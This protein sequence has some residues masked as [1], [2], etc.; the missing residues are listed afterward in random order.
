MRH[1]ALN[2]FWFLDNVRAVCAVTHGVTD[3][4]KLSN[5]TADFAGSDTQTS[6]IDSD[7]SAKISPRLCKM[8]TRG[9]YKTIVSA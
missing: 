4:C 3:H 8:A 7:V 1:I 9:I 5:F 6:S 2:F